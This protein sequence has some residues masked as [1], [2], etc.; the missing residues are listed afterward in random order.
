MGS[1]TKKS[2]LVLCGDYMEDYDVVVPFFTLRAFGV[3][4]DCVSGGKLPGH[5]C[6][7]AVHDFMGFEADSYDCLL[8]PGGGLIELLSAD[9]K[10][11]GLVRKFEAGKPVVTSYHSQI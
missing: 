10:T 3:R 5:R 9:D 7:T 2:V 8:I 4:V 6:F 1:L 11:V